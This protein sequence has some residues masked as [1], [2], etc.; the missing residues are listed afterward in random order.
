MSTVILSAHRL[1][2]LLPLIA[3]FCL[4]YVIQT[5]RLDSKARSSMLI[6]LCSIGCWAL[7]SLLLR[8]SDSAGEATFW[9]R[10]IRAA[11]TIMG[12]AALHFVYE[13]LELKK[14]RLV[15]ISYA[16]SSF[17][18]LAALTTGLVVA[19]VG[20]NMWGYFGRPGPLRL[21]C[22]IFSF[23]LLLYSF[24]LLLKYRYSKDRIL[25]K[26]VGITLVAFA[27]I[28][29]GAISDLL[30]TIGIP[31]YPASMITNTV[32]VVLIAYGAFEH[33]LLGVVSRPQ[34]RIILA[35]LAYALIATGLA[36]SV[37][38]SASKEAFVFLLALLFI[39]FDVYHFFDDITYL[40]RKYLRIRQRPYLYETVNDASI[41][42]NDRDIG[43]AALNRRREILFANRKAA[44][45][46]GK[47]V[48]ENKSLEFLQNDILRRKLTKCCSH[49][50]ETIINVD[51]DT[52]AEIMPIELGGY[53]GTL[54][55][56]YPRSKRH[57]FEEVKR[58]PRFK[59]ISFMDIFP[60]E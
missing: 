51:R 57:V 30:P 4:I 26:E 59:R 12:A 53:V 5:H 32:F 48:I 13:L 56:F 46:L 55:C 18:V 27:A 52:C 23:S 25:Y 21:S 10:F 16:L 35:M 14:R 19:P 45:I 41:L 1:L 38:E 37:T 11:A 34:P 22:T 7:G 50:R 20:E 9:A 17:I 33:Q 47:D 43:I 54:L 36:L 58:T 24:V 40:A 3:S 15:Y 6:Y 39:V 31:F 49:R 44:K 29:L 60:E 28:F 42:F 8:N 2:P